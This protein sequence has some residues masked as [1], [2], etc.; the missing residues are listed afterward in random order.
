MRTKGLRNRIVAGLMALVMIITTWIPTEQVKADDSN[1]PA[2]TNTTFATARELQFNTSIAEELTQ[3][4]A[5]RYYKFSVDEA[6]E[7]NIGATIGSRAAG[8]KIYIYDA[9]KTE[10]YC[11]EK[12]GSSWINDFSTGSIYLTG[13]MY[14][15]EIEEYSVD[16]TISFVATLDSMGETF[17]ETQDVNND[18]IDNASSIALKTKYKGALTQNDEVD[19][20]KFTVPAAGRINFNMTNATNGTLKY[21]IYDS[22]VNA[23]YIKTVAENGKVSEYITLAKG[24]YYLA[25]TKDD[26]KSGVGSYNFNI[27][28]V[29]NV[30]TAPKIKSV[31]NTSKKKMTVKWSKVTGADGYE[32]QYSIKS[33]FK[34]KVVKKTISASKTSAAYSKLTKGKTYY[35]RMRSYVNVDGVKKYSSWSSKKSV[36]IKK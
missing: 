26:S 35:V 17:A 15:L 24:T 9:S 25:I 6:S 7:L 1:L 30:P 3:K 23:T 11:F 10:V 29:A 13:G 5:K 18:V 4:D 22:S 16:S 32:L 36:K 20:Y 14:Y 19:Y 21:A 12:R 33:N 34:S 27:D 2:A 8:I 31:K 28:Y